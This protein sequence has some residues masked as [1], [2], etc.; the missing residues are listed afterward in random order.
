[1]GYIV[2]S[3]APNP[4]QDEPGFLAKAM[5][6]QQIEV[7]AKRIQSK[8]ALFVFD[9]CFS[10]SLFA[11]SRAA[12]ESITYKTT[13]PV[14]QF[15]T[16]GSAKEPVP[17]ESIFRQQFI[18]ALQGDGDINND[19]YVTGEEL[20]YFL[21]DTVVNYSKGT[22]HPQYGKI[23]DPHLD[24][25]DFVFKVTI[26]VSVSTSTASSEHVEFV[27]N[28]DDDRWGWSVRTSGKN[29]DAY[30]DNGKYIIQRKKP[31]KCTVEMITPPFNMPEHVDIELASIWKSGQVDNQ[32]Y[33][34]VLGSSRN[35]YYVF[36]IYGDGG[37]KV[38]LALNGRFGHSKPESVMVDYKSGKAFPGDGMTSNVQK[39]QIRGDY[40]L[41]Y[42]NNKYIG[43]VHNTELKFDRNDWRIGVVVCQQQEVAFDQLKIAEKGGVDSSS[44]QKV[45]TGEFKL[46]YRYEGAYCTEIFVLDQDGDSLSGIR[47]LTETDSCCTATTSSPVT[48]AIIDETTAVLSWPGG[49]AKCAGDNG[50]SFHFD[51]TNITCHVTLSGNGQLLSRDD[52]NKA[53]IRQ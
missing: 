42:V 7:Y 30:F 41:Y 16:A 2:P 6:M 11:L 47:K 24:K 20:G 12:P 5:D 38:Y 45:F 9:S 46:E 19:G 29:S 35:N 10:G 22:Q 18:A 44:T 40:F 26:T 37:A 53:Y 50:C 25:G 3:D 14:R 32:T 15:I 1:M 28:F 52:R 43:R 39:I 4:H 8:H 49:D 33:G 34:L 13:E 36:S 27:E 31:E 17:D 48:G 51:Y 23:R 21:Q